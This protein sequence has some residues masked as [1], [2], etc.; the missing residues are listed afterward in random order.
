MEIDLPGLLALPAAERLE[1][2][3]ILRDSV[4]WPADI[5]RPQLPAWRQAHLDR[6][7]RQYAPNPGDDVP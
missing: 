3:A 2:A 6:L 1:V 5:D 4:G 7:L